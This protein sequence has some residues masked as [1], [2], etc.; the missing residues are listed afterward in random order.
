M[1]MLYD[2]CGAGAN[3]LAMQSDAAEV[4]RFCA[5]DPQVYLASSIIP[6][7]DTFSLMIALSVCAAIVFRELFRSADDRA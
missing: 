7:V 5:S 3:Y 1:M 4:A 6:G 2:P